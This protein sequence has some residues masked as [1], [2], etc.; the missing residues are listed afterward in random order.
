MTA[1]AFDEWLLGLDFDFWGT[2]Q[3]KVSSTQFFERWRGGEG[4]T[5]L[6]VRTSQEGEIIAFPFALHI[7]VEDLPT[8]WE[9]IPRTGLVAIFCSSGVRS[10]IAYAYLQLK[11]LENVRV[12]AGGYE[13]L[14]AELKPGKLRKLLQAI[15]S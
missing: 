10:A 8:S 2:A 1:D 3:H 11:G 4:V 15:E 12:L 14:V 13:E 6:D 7:P 5:L 9:S